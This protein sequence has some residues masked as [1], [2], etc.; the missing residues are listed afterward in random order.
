MR[1]EAI[2]GSFSDTIPDSSIS[3]K[4]ENNEIMNKDYIT[5]D[6]SRLIDTYLLLRRR[7]IVNN[8]IP[9]GFLRL[10]N[11]NLDA[12]W[13]STRTINMNNSD[14]NMKRLG[15][16]MESKTKIPFHAFLCSSCKTR[17]SARVPCFTCNLKHTKNIITCYNFT[18]MK[19]SIDLPL[20]RNPCALPRE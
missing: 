19:P 4:Y 8:A 6:C 5:R 7:R 1:H 11:A 17:M 16:A 12:T 13:Y 3:W 2:R 14:K 18:Q 9:H 10:R 20:S 15:C